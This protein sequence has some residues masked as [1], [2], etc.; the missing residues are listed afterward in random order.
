ME[1]RRAERRGQ[2][3]LAPREVALH[4][5]DARP[6]VYVHEAALAPV[7]LEALKLARH[8]PCVRIEVGPAEPTGDAIPYARFVARQ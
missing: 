7:V 3:R 1:L 2:H 6:A 5:D 4:Q 8:Q